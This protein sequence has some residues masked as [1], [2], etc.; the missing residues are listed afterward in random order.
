MKH[1]QYA[2]WSLLFWKVRTAVKICNEWYIY[3]APSDQFCFIM[4]LS[5]L[6]QHKS[7]SVRYIPTC[8]WWIKLFTEGC[9]LP[10]EIEIMKGQDNHKENYEF[11]RYVVYQTLK[12]HS[13]RNKQHVF[14]WGIA[15]KNCQF[16][17]E[18]IF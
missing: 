7:E 18:D 11:V 5:Q 4:F 1:I 16:S 15:W 2:F 13:F 17:T 6:R 12:N 10:N 9:D 14:F 8:V 3:S